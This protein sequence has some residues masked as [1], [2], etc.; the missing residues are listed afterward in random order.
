MAFTDFTSLFFFERVARCQSFKLAAEELHLTQSA[1]SHRIRTLESRLGFVLF[2]RQTR[3][4][5]LTA[6]G[7]RLFL[8]LNRNFAAVTDEVEDIRFNALRGT[9]SV[10]CTPTFAQHWLAPRLVSF[11]H[12]YPD[13]S[14]QLRSKGSRVDFN[15]YPSDLWI[16]YGDGHY[17]GLSVTLLFDEVLLPVCSP[18]YARQ[19]QLHDTPAALYDC[20]LLHDVESIEQSDYRWEWRSWFAQAGLGRLEHCREYNFTH[21]DAAIIAARSGLGVA[22]GRYRL[23]KPLL[24]Q[25]ELTAPFD[26]VLNPGLAYYLVARKDR[27]Q[28]PRAHAFRTWIMDEIG[29]SNDSP[30]QA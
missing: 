2:T 22:M 4:I 28:Q 13:L 27:I 20:L 10:G 16:D 17:P 19:M 12:R 9:L 23:A 8:L 6:E 21:Y 5:R 26:T 1:L 29:I 7:E 3:Q 15:L 30:V 24:D 14:L 18:D 11:H 25:G